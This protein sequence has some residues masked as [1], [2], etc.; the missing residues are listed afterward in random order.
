LR[1][2]Y[3]QIY[4]LKEGPSVIEQLPERKYVSQRMIT[5]F[6]MNWDGHPEPKDE[7]WI[8]FKVVNQIKQITKL[9]MNYRFK[10]MPPEMIWYQQKADNKWIVE[11]MILVPDFISE[12]IYIRALEKVQKS[13]RVDTLPS[14]SFKHEQETLT[15]MKLHVG[16]YKD[17]SSS[18]ALLEK[19]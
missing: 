9:E 11:R 18:L 12:E 7:K 5:S 13:L 1:K 6:H 17:T 16:H 19:E 8:A 3:Q 14:I 4:Y 2:V 10:R 15:A